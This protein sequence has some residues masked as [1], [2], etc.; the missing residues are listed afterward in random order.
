MHSVLVR[1]AFAL[2]LSLACS[3]PTRTD[4]SNGVLLVPG[5]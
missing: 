1:L 4:L 2:A 5:R 3:A